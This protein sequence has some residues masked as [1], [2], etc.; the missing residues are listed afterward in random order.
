MSEALVTLTIDGLEITV[1]KGT[2]IID[3]AKMIGVE[4]PAFCYHPKMKP[5]GACRQC[6]VEIGRPKIDRKTRQIVRQEN[7][8]PLIEFG[9]KLETACSTPVGE[10]WVVRVNSERAR[11]GRKEILEMLLTSH[12]L[13]C[14]VCDKGGECPLQDLTMRH[15]PG[16]SRFL[17]EEKMH[18]A[19][20]VPL[21]G[22]I[23]LDRERC[24]QCGRCLRFQYDVVDDPVI[25][26]AQRGRH[27]EIVTSSDPG[28]NSNFSGNSTDICPVG[29][30]TTADFRFGARP[31]ELNCSA[32]VCTHCAVGCNLMINTRRAARAAGRDVVKRIMPRQ[33][34]SVNEIWICD[35]G[36]FAHHFAASPKRL[37]QPL[38]RVEG[39]LQ[40]TSWEKALAR[41]TEGLRSAG[42][43]VIGVA[44]G[45]ASNEDLFYLRM[46]MEGLGGRAVLHSTM[47]GGDLVQQLGPGPGSNLADLGSDDA[48]LVVAS[49]LHEEAPIWWL[50]VK[51]AAER[52]ASL[53]VANARRTRLDPYATHSLRYANW[54]APQAVLGLLHA[55]TGK[56]EFA[57][58]KGGPGYAPAGSVLAKADNLVIFYGTEGLDYEA[59][60][61]LAQACANLLVRTQHLGRPNNGLIAV[62]P[63]CNTQGAWDMGLRP[64]P[65]GLAGPL[66][67]AKAALVLAADPVGD[68]PH[69]AKDFQ[70]LDCLIVQEL[71]LSETAKL[72][73]VVLPAQSFIERQATFTSGERR[74]QRTYPAVRPWGESRADWT[75]LADVGERV[76]I[77]LPRK[78]EAAV[79]AQI[80]SRIGDYAEVS[81]EA[82]AQSEPQW[83]P[84]G[85]TDNYFGGTAYR[86]TQGLG[87]AL[88][89]GAQRGESITVPW[90]APKE[91]APEGDLL[92]VPVAQLLERGST[93]IPSSLLEERLAPAVVRM[94]ALDAKRLKVEHAEQVELTWKGGGVRLDVAIGEDVPQGAALIARSN[95]VGLVRPVAVKVRPVKR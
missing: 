58:F 65:Q 61:A 56:K 81:Y 27:L 66:R 53:V 15:G 90:T 20:H 84:V 72:A 52:G 71:F 8:E 67:K 45:R 5:A 23:W 73:D 37:A 10:G 39:A 30:L 64:E 63:R 50:R 69:L 86:N 41:A 9:P 87:V 92:L 32:S 77:A 55:A 38:M 95:G 42:K 13:D 51:Q 59:S 24:I 29:A 78:G 4:I 21:G 6:L 2:M 31:W 22:L 11:Q 83:P 19:K 12:P 76:G 43:A 94:H 40:E 79:M 44:G 35:K 48:I 80:A 68:E 60:Q 1:P 62:W 89:S 33:N 26:F 93:V 16:E 36:R 54:A 14:P 85:G 49:D 28:F 47:A 17:Y 57:S 82:L 70:G 18:L 74:V 75:I 25:A 3:A 46:L 34:E 7:G 91:Y 88:R